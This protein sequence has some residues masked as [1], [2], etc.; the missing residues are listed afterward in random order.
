MADDLNER[1]PADRSRV[2]LSED[3]ERRYWTKALGCSDEQLRS[4]VKAVGNSADAVKAHLSH[5]KH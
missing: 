2:S 5:G 1:G 4:A 3:W